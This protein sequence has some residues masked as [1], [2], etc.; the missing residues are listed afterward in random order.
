MW[1]C[2]DEEYRARGVHGQALAQSGMRC[3]GADQRGLPRRS[4]ANMGWGAPAGIQCV[5]LPSSSKAK[6][7]SYSFL[8]CSKSRSVST[9]NRCSISLLAWLNELLSKQKKMVTWKPSDFW[10]SGQ[11]QLNTPTSNTRWLCWSEGWVLPLQ[12]TWFIPVLF[13][14]LTFRFGLVILCEWQVVSHILNECV[15]F[16]F[17]ML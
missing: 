1:Q 10:A 9:H 7:A 15:V 8:C 4:D 17:S 5:H 6:A 13:F 2:Y 14:F 16:C 3:D 11:P 12:I